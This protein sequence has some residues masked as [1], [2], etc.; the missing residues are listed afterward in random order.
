MRMQL[1]I[2]SEFLFISF[3]HRAQ[4]SLPHS[5]F[6]VSNDFWAF[7]FLLIQLQRLAPRGHKPIPARKKKTTSCRARLMLVEAEH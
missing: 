5:N 4:K 1:S 3:G 2:S 6:E 7:Y